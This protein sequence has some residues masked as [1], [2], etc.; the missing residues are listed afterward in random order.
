MNQSDQQRHLVVLTGAGVSA[1]SGLQTF[2]DAGGLWEGHSVYEVA[3]PEAWRENPRLVLDFY[4]ARRRMVRDAKPNLAH[5]LLAQLEDHFQVTIVTQNIDDLHERAGSTDVMHLH[6]EIAKAQSADDP[7]LIVECDGD[8]KWGDS[9]PDGTQLRPHVVWF[10]EPILKWPE[11]TQAAQAADLFIVIGTSLQV[12][13]AAGLLEYVPRHCT[14]YLID[15]EI[16]A[17]YDVDHFRLFAK[18]ATAGMQ[19]VY[20]ELVGDARPGM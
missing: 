6:G 12:Y 17:R 4:N 15:R 16:P 18:S 14:R 9:A 8:I 2:R 19:E 7:S 13:P 1:E 5:T 11:A 3:T 20:K 10:G